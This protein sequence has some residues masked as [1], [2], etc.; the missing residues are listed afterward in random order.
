MLHHAKA[1][2]LIPL[3]L[4]TLALSGLP[5]RAAEPVSHAPAPPATNVLARRVVQDVIQ[6]SNTFA[7]FVPGSLAEAVWA[8]SRTN[9]RS[10]RMWEY[11]QLPAGWPTN[12]PV[13]RWDTNNLLWGRQG[14]TAI[15]QVCQGM[16]AFGQGA[17]TA[18]TP[19]HGYVRGHGMGTS[20]VHPERAGQRVWFC[21]R[22][23]QV[24][25]RKVQLLVVRFLDASHPGDYSIMLF[26]A[27][28]PPAIEPM[29][30]VDPVQVRRK[31]LFLPMEHK[32]VFMALQG[33]IVTA[34]VGGW[35]IG[36]SGGDSGNPRML[37]LHGELLFLEGVST[38]PPSA[39]MQA[40]MDR[41]SR[42]AGLDPRRYQ[43][44]WV[45]LAGYPDF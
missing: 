13:L 33:G 25:E 4:L 2:I 3:M 9:G 42:Q 39:E 15:S 43:L 14:M 28:L 19:R 21:T 20:G 30:V 12:P 24:I 7:G 6:I 18:L 22:D 40:D 38:S 17:I 36:V 44:Q 27:D 11:W 16:G 1:L 10:P 26:D 32:P 45:S 29:R 8:D 31:Y 23:N 35:D 34:G 5:S 41:L 37:P